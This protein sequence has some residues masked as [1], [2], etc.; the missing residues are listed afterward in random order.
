M[1]KLA[2]KE[3]IAELNSLHQ[4]SAIFG[5]GSVTKKHYSKIEKII[6]KGNLKTVLDYGCGKGDL[7]EHLNKVSPSVEVDGFDVANEKYADLKSRSYDLVVALDVLEHIEF[8]LLTNVLSE[9]RIRTNSIFFC[10]VANYP[11]AKILSD[12]RNAHL[13][14]IP[15][16]SWFSTLSCFFQVN[17]FIRT[18]LQEGLFICSKLSNNADWR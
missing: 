6:E 15:F 16:G 2:S 12:G 4:K 14:Q 7:I 3:Y 10:S 9:I 1:K 5:A 13:I 18:G 11:A 17:Q 8:G